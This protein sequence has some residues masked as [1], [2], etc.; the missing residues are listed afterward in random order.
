MQDHSSPSDGTQL[1]AGA[2]EAPT[3][4]AAPTTPAALVDV[5][6]AAVAPAAEHTLPAPIVTAVTPAASTAP[7]AASTAATE[8]AK[9]ELSEADYGKAPRTFAEMGLHDDVA[10]ALR[11]MGFSEPMPVQQRVFRPVVA[12]RD[13][14]VQSRTGSG[15]TA[16]FGIPFVQSV[17]E[18]DA[19]VKNG[20][21]QVLV[22]G[23]TREL[24]LQVAG[25]IGRIAARRKLAITAVYG[26]A[27]MGRQ[28][29]ALKAGAHLVSGTPGRVLDHLRR[30]TLHLSRVKALVLDEADEMLSMGFLED[31][32]EILRRCPSDRQTLLFSATMPDEV[33]R[34]QNRYLRAPLNIQL[35]NEGI[36]AAEIVH[37][38][39]MV[40][41][42]GRM[43]DLLRVIEIERPESAIIFCNTREET[44]AVAEFL[45]NNGHDAEPISSDLTQ[46]ER[47]RVMKRMK[48][49]DLKFLCATDVA[50]R[51]I[52]IS[53]LPFVI[54][55]TFPESAEVYVH[56][57]GRTGR[58]GKK[59]IAVS[60]ISPREL[61]NFYY[62]KLTYKI[63]PEERA[64]PTEAE[65]Q[66]LREG[67]YMDRLQKDLVHRNPGPEFRSLLRR[68]LASESGESILALL[69]EE[70]LQKPKSARPAHGSESHSRGHERR[71][72]EDGRSHEERRP[73]DEGRSHE[74]RRPRDEERRP[75]SDSRPAQAEAPPQVTE[76][77]PAAT[78]VRPPAAEAKPAATE[79][80]PPAAEAK[81]VVAPEVRSPTADAPPRGEAR[82]LPTDTDAARAE[83]R[84]ST[85]DRRPRDD[86]RGRDDDRRS[87]DG[88]RDDRRDRDRDR[89]GPRRPD[90]PAGARG[91][92]QV[93]MPGASAPSTALD[94][95]HTDDGREFWEAWADS[96]AKVTRTDAPAG[97]ESAPRQDAPSSVLVP[98][99]GDVGERRPR[100]PLRD[101]RPPIAGEV[102]LYMNVGRRDNLDDAALRTFV[103]AQGIGEIPME[104]HSSH[105]Y[106]FVPEAQVDATIAALAGKPLG[107]RM[108]VCERARR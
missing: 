79:V 43:R 82:P 11:D 106:L 68:L 21:P 77:K 10:G 86:R 103:S 70:H 101:S 50:A 66:T 3:A 92:E 37:A 26:G 14:I 62:L 42:M 54:N 104:L 17:L 98:Q 35:S 84:S 88:R 96:R 76:T 1:L 94:I 60:L 107:A 52:D 15:K 89:R 6:V 31:I 33:L 30:G 40:T 67:H 55:Y 56:R 108:V 95:I 47:E 100:R 74:E 81:P 38:Y 32:T 97:T 2:A 71:P 75:R 58:A 13:L 27:P 25:E 46:A 28:V 39:Y 90:E 85:D 73:R 99:D 61:G 78:E 19:D 93:P 91:A 8:P 41:G 12:G 34:L 80:R 51:G 20:Y 16:A 105:A 57:T 53:D 36:S 72:R 7:T 24:A 45:R 44:G 69:L 102:R 22:L 23:P 48:A 29:E 63:R 87:R 83:A 9:P 65:I 5:P 64:L 4:T 59:G 49:K 18:S